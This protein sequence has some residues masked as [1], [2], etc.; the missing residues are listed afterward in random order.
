[1][2]ISNAVP[3]NVV[4]SVVGY[5]LK[6]GS[7]QTTTANLP[8]SI[9]ILGEGTT[10]KQ[11][12]MPLVGTQIT[13]AAQA[14]S[15]FGAGSPIHSAARILF[16]TSGGGVNVP[17]WVYA[18]AAAS[19]AVA[20]AQS[21]TV[22]GTATASGTHYIKIAGRE[23]IDGAV[24][25]INIVTGDTPSQIAQK[26][27]DAINNSIFCP[28]SAI[29]GAILN[30]IA[31]SS[32]GAAGSGYRVNDQF[33]ISGGSSSAIGNVVSVSNAALVTAAVYGSAGS[34]YA[35]SDTFNVVGGATG[36]IASVTSITG[37]ISSTSI[38]AAGSGYALGDTFNVTTGGTG[39]SGQVISI[40]DGYLLTADPTG[41]TGYAVGDTFMVPDGALGTVTAVTAGMPTAITIS[42][43]GQN[44]N[45]GTLYGTTATS[46]SGTGLFIQP[47]T[48][49]NGTVASYTISSAGSGYTTGNNKSTSATSGTGT[50]FKITISAVNS[51]T[52]IPATVTIVTGGSGYVVGSHYTAVTTSG[53]GTGMQLTASTILTGAVL[54]YSIV[55]AG[56]GYSVSSGVATTATVG[57]GSGLT[58]NILSVAS[59]GVNSL[60]ATA[61]W[62]GLTSQDITIEMD[63]NNTSLGV[64]YAI[65]EVAAGSGTPT[66]TASLNLFG[67]KWHT[68]VI[69]TYGLVS[70]T[71]TELETFNGTPNP[72]TA[73][74]RYV[75]T[76]FK[77]FI[78]L[79][80]STLDDPSSITDASARKT[81]VT[82]A[83]CPAPLSLGLPY[84]AAANV[85]LLLANQA[86]ANPHSDCINKPYPDMPLPAADDTP[87]MNSFTERDRIVK[88]GCS[89]VDIVSGVYTII[90]LVTTYHPDGENPPQWRWVRSLVID[91]NV[92]FGYRL[93]VIQ[94]Q[95][96][97]TIANDGDAVTVANVITPGGWKAIVFDYITDLVARALIADAA[98]SKTSTA[99]E[100]DENNPDRMNTIW[101]Y[102]RTGIDRVSANTVKA[103]FNFG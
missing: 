79:S 39:A 4:S 54:S 89:T 81:Q 31:T 46:G 34:G 60:T 24:Y 93:R 35:V 71:V 77:P 80:G 45:T 50:G 11:S 52:G 86:D 91:M 38:Y 84:E 51:L 101:S 23:Q 61:K 97:N 103:G 20:N 98:F 65:A 7:F 6:K 8:Q 27:Y 49:A 95:V 12:S 75:P 59:T 21:I 9:A 87:L 66:V 43:G 29:R 42:A 74:G 99:V 2:A 76:V 55:S 5:D 30:R 57:S 69:N 26:A 19:G 33:S 83:V 58:I 102:K 94:Y 36:T 78:A 85:A 73:T 14:A 47:A 3:T 16:P 68:I 40:I 18:Q 82:I 56:A 37:R 17:V 41:G 1:M 92:E 88:K 63:T 53:S 32:I 72:D 44:Y 13:S 70:A 90:D 100:I 28:V 64:T 96:G 25:A 62:A 10:A 15:L 48:V 67:N 22:T